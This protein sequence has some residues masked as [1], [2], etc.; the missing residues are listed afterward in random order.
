MPFE[1]MWFASV[2]PQKTAATK[3]PGQTAGLFIIT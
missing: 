1:R 3:K 2:G